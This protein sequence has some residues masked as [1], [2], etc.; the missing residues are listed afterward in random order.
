MQQVFDFLKG[1]R[2][3]NNKNW[4]DAHKNEYKEIQ[5]KIEFLTRDL[6]KYLSNYNPELRSLQPADCLYRINRD[7][8]FSKDKTP[9]KNHIGIFIAQGG[10][11]NGKAGYY[12]HFEPETENEEGH[13]LL[14]AGTYMLDN[15]YLKVIREDIWNDY[16]GFRS[17]LRAASG[18]CLDES[19]KLKQTPHG[20]PKKTKYD[21]YLT[22]KDFCLTRKLDEEN[23]LREGNRHYMDSSQSISNGMLAHYLVNEIHTTHRFVEFLNRAINF[24]DEQ[25]EEEITW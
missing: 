23:L 24:V 17:I 19:N 4:F 11:K 25:V 7:I 6:I 10:K 12:F 21:K 15:K 9:Y 18:F 2:A 8:R 1:L 13:S 16:D 20:Y 5:T 22:L 14:A 3:N